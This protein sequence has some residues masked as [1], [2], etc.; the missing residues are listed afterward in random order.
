MRSLFLLLIL[1][2]LIASCDDDKLDKKGFQVREIIE[3]EEGEKIVGL[4][5]D[6]LKLETRPRNVLFTHS[7]THRITPI[8]KVNYKN[9]GKEAFTGSN[10]FIRSWGHEFGEGI[11]N[12][13][14]NYMPGFEVVRGYNFV[15]VS[16]Y[17]N[18]VNKENKLFKK[19]VLIKHFYYPTPDKDTLNS[20]PVHRDY[21][22]ASVYDEDTNKDGY[23][24]VKDLRRLY[25][26]DMEG[27]NQRALVPT[28]YSVMS[29][30]YDAMNDYMYIFARKDANG[31]GQMDISEPFDVFWI[32]L[33]EPARVGVQYRSE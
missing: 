33:N 20:I 27:V 1:T 15:N 31:N 8:Y 4:K 19:P 29:S 11:N 5:I 13:H 18:E 22:M 28:N 14:N 26:F 24:T 16:H 17:N 7:P 2:T 9:D 23:V 3:T 12:W 21:Y 10:D 25:Y 30:E 32:D 6:S